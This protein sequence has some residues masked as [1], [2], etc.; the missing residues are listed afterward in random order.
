MKPQYSTAGVLSVVIAAP[1]LGI[2]S[3]YTNRGGSVCAWTT[4]GQLLGTAIQGLIVN[5]QF[6]DALAAAVDK[7]DRDPE[8]DHSTSATEWRD[9]L[10][11]G[12][13]DIEKALQ[14]NPGGAAA[15]DRH[16]EQRGATHW[17]GIELVRTLADW[18]RPMTEGPAAVVHAAAGMAGL[19]S[20]P[21]LRLN[22]IATAI[23]D[24]AVGSFWRHDPP[25][26]A[27]LK[28]GWD[29]V[30]VCSHPPRPLQASPEAE[31]W[32]RLQSPQK[33]HRIIDDSQPDHG[34]SMPGLIEWLESLKLADT[35]RFRRFPTE[36]VPGPDKGGSA[37]GGFSISR[38]LGSLLDSVSAKNI[39][40]KQL[41]SNRAELRWYFH[42]LLRHK[43]YTVREVLRNSTVFV[44][45]K[46]PFSILCSQAEL[47]KLNVPLRGEIWK[48]HTDAINPV[49]TV[50]KHGDGQNSSQDAVPLPTITCSAM[51][52]FPHDQT[53][54]V[55]RKGTLIELKYERKAGRIT[56]KNALHI[57]S[58]AV[59]S[60]S[61]TGDVV[62]LANL[63]EM[64]EWEADFVLRWGSGS[65]VAAPSPQPPNS[66]ANVQLRFRA[67]PTPIGVMSMPE[68]RWDTTNQSDDDQ[69]LRMI[70]SCSC[71]HTASDG[72]PRHIAELLASFYTRLS[73]LP[74]SD[75]IKVPLRAGSFHLSVASFKVLLTSLAH[76]DGGG[77]RRGLASLFIEPMF[78]RVCAP[79]DAVCRPSSFTLAIGH[80]LGQ[81]ACGSPKGTHCANVSWFFGRET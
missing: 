43:G 18:I 9:S 81:R 66:P 56:D 76:Y 21:L 10:V 39:D 26:A 27:V 2:V 12:Y 4:I 59:R 13:E 49:I 41:Y 68:A 67:R 34:F 51:N 69:T 64:L 74:E 48:L 58:A 79:D 16:N 72:R 70:E 37:G 77:G 11:R 40:K 55:K 73:E 35:R 60:F 75:R 1:T 19:G 80:P 22:A 23:A 24:S 31:Q 78:D 33:R 32:G 52:T 45:I 53:R 8:S 15:S 29:L 5:S 63:H 14:D 17:L 30:W 44:F 20:G 65:S 3:N 47:I 42:E 50:S 6:P 28:A 54:P 36:L 62:M 57:F 25:D 38:L 61:S 7:C 71:A 46:A